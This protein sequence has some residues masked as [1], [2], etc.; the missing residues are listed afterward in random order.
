MLDHP[1][2]FNKYKKKINVS[3]KLKVIF[4]NDILEPYSI[5]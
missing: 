2:K 5:N 1:N 4:K 3:R